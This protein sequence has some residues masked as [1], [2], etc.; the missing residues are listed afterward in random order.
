M[1]KSCLREMTVL[2]AT[3]NRAPVLGE[4]L[5]AMGR[6]ERGSA[7]VRFVVVDNGSTDE[8]GA[9]IETASR[10]LDITH[11]S[12]PE[13]GKWRA[14]NHAL[15]TF[16]LGDIVVLTDDDV[17]PC[18]GWFRAIETACRRWPGHGVFGGRITVQWP[19]IP[20]PG[21]VHDPLIHT[22]GYVHHYYGDFECLYPANHY[23][24]SP[25]LWVRR[26]VV[27]EG[28]RFDERMGPRVVHRTMGGETLFA[29]RLAEAGHAPVYCP[30]AEV[31][32]R[33]QAEAVSASAIRR[34]AVTFGRGS[35]YLFGYPRS[36]LRKRL[37]WAWWAMRMASL[38]RDSV[39]LG[40]AMLSPDADARVKRSVRALY[41]LASIIE[42][43]R[44]REDGRT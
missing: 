13:G 36:A 28:A 44:M 3:R 4:T 30:A 35:P 6:V 32:H 7:R 12:V 25:N 40:L 42:S 33:V 27:D 41:R 19:N 15:D 37:P 39:G 26:R 11:L 21:W 34:R 43:L 38:C 9:V 8:T 1:R 22:F 5:R 31:R 23:P 2:I 10:S 14:V 24:F 17:E 29:K 20:L 18:A 16:D